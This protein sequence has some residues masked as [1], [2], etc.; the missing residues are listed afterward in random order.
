LQVDRSLSDDL[1]GDIIKLKAGDCSP[2]RNSQGD[3]GPWEYQPGYEEV[4]RAL[5]GM[6]TW[7]GGNDRPIL[8]PYGVVNHYGRG[9]HRALLLELSEHASTKMQGTLASLVKAVY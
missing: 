2:A 8:W 5:T 3:Q 7:F 4:V 9:L 6:Q 1:L